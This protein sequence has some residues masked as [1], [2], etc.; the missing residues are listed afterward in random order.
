ML[1][2]VDHSYPLRTTTTSNGIKVVVNPDPWVSG[3]AV[4]LWYDVGSVHE[5]AGKT[6]FAHL[7]E[8]LMFSGSA[9]VASGEHLGVLQNI[10][11]NANATTS[12]D[13]TNYFETVPR[14]GLELAL[15]LEADRLA[16]LLDSVD[17]TNLDTQREV[18]KEEK[19][20]RYDNV[21]YGNA[22][23]ELMKL[24]FP[25]GHPYAHM[26]IGSMDDLDQA[27]LA[28]VH[29]FFHRH[30]SPDN[31]ILTLSGD[32]QPDE[33]FALVET[34]FHDIAPAGPTPAPDLDPLSGLTGIPRLELTADVP[35]DVVYCSWIV[36]PVAADEA[37][38][39]SVGL[40]I[41]SGSM[42]SRLHEQLVRTNLADSVDAFD[43]GLK[44][45]NS[46]VVATAACA[47]STSPEVVEAAMMT[48]WEQFCA[49]GP[50]ADEL[51]RAKKAETRQFLADL[52]SIDDRADHISA[53][54]S[55]FG[56]PAEINRHL[57]VINALTAADINRVFTTWMTPSQRA[58]LTYRSAQ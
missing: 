15:W 37:D 57:D 51:D 30:Y 18:V 7:F 17:Q 40:S 54:W 13:R 5:Q 34:Y 58:V 39:L 25:D 4:N 9:H 8:H 49:E 43:L 2:A 48:T 55:L 29:D 56:D 3:V 52:A 6:G 12:F 23:P 24:S 45:A 14:G 26:P 28:D 19:R 35:Q 1:V 32:I 21:P 10:G 44:H 20:Q 36:P 42:T 31:L 22:F 38:P 47:G 11:G 41:L 33:G 16:S 53:S 27:T 46:L 50:R